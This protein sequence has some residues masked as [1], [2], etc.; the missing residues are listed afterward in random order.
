MSRL[1]V[2][3]LAACLSFTTLAQEKAHS[4][5]GLQML[6][7]CD[8]NADGTVNVLD[9]QVAI[10]M[11]LGVVPCTANISNLGVCDVIVVQ[12]IINASLGGG[13]LTGP[14]IHTVTLNWTASTSSDITGYNVYRAVLDGGPYTKINAF[15]VAT[16]SFTDPAAQAGAT[17]FY[18]TTA[19]DSN[20]NES[21]YSNQAQAVIP[22]P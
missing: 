9:A 19:I 15:P 6:N 20:N 5:A 21:A 10:N 13:C 14:T 17:Y 4:A 16:T 2:A 22:N 7:Q 18:V 12:R 3:A 8:L 11:A 1:C